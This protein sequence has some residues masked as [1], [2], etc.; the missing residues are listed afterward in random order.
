MFWGWER[1]EEVCRLHE[2][3]TAETKVALQPLE[4]FF[5]FSF[6]MSGRWLINVF[7]CTTQGP[8]RAQQVAEF[9]SR[10]VPKRA[11]M[12]QPLDVPL[13]P[14]SCARSSLP[15]GP[16]CS[17]QGQRDSVRASCSLLPSCLPWC[18][19]ALSARDGEVSARLTDEKCGFL[20]L[21]EH[22]FPPT[23]FFSAVLCATLLNL[24]P[25][26]EDYLKTQVRIYNAF[27]NS[28][29]M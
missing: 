4:Y 18:D 1:S 7:L 28:S 29:H 2:K 19:T 22:F 8:G 9:V 25:I 11:R 14:L 21:Q 13:A 26:T 27:L 17:W 16:A 5:F 23:P 10:S 3:C 6:C 20:P 12:Q 15:E 24:L